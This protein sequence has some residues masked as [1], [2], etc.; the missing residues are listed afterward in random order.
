MSF[1]SVIN[2]LVIKEMIDFNNQETMRWSLVKYILAE[3]YEKN[4]FFLNKCC[5]IDCEYNYRTV[6]LFNK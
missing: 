1:T 4:I 3:N 2:L 5:L 6:V